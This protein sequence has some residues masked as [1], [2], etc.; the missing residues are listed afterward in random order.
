MNSRP[1]TVLHLTDLPIGTLTLTA[2]D[3][4]LT[5]VRFGWVEEATL[6][7]VPNDML[8]EAAHQLSEYFSGKRLRFDLPLAPLGTSFQQRVWL[9]LCSIPYGKT[10][11]YGELAE[12][13]G[14]PAAARAVGM[15]NNRN[16]I[17]VI[18][19]CHRVIGADGALV[20]YGGGLN[21]KEAL[22]RHEGAL[23]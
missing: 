6:E 1:T 12:R 11:S 18:I 21:I 20:G 7:Q 16:P 5:G 2:N 19:P 22:L 14:Q 9:G 3:E 23:D 10:L 15:A 13:I 8:I 4:A 17:P